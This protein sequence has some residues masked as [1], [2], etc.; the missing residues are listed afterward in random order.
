MREYVGR[1]AEAGLHEVLGMGWGGG[2]G[3][4]TAGDVVCASGAKHCLICAIQSCGSM[5]KS[6]VSR[7]SNVVNICSGSV[8]S[9]PCHVLTVRT[10]PIQH[11]LSIP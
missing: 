1:G 4:S 2:S 6:S 3:V 9:F 8:D 5:K 11:H 10:D 7:T